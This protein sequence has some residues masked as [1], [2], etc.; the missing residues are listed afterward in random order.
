MHTLVLTGELDGTSAHV[1]EAEIERVCAGAGGIT[2]DLGGLA[3]ID[4]AGVA[5][6]VFQ[7]GLWRRRGYEFALARAP[8]A[9]EQALQL[10]EAAGGPAQAAGGPAQAAV[11]TAEQPARRPA[12]PPRRRRVRAPAKRLAP[13]GASR[14]PSPARGRTGGA[15]V[16]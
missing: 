3:R 4:G 12:R 13:A 15:I 10:A 1:L 16:L 9:I 11:G 2:L 5:V 14:A 7:S 6:I 8:L